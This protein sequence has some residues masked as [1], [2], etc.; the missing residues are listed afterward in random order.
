M[1]TL[2]ESADPGSTF[3]GW[4]GDCTGSGA[5]VVTMDAVKNVTATF[6]ITQHTLTVSLAGTGS[7]TVTSAPAGIDCD[8]DCTEDYDEDTVV[9][10]SPSADPGSTFVAWSG[11]CTGSG[12]CMVTMDAAKNVTA[13]FD[14]SGT[15]QHTL[16]VS[17]AGTGSGTVMSD[18]AGISCD[19]DC[20]EDY[21]EDTVVT[22]TATEDPGST[23]SGWNGAGCSG[24]GDC[25]VTM[26]A[27]KN[28]TAT[29]DTTPSGGEIISLTQVDHFEMGWSGGTSSGTPLTIP[30]TDAAG[31]TY[32]PPSGHLFISDS[33]INEI[34]S[35]FAVAGGNIFEISLSGDTLFNT[36]DTTPTAMGKN[37]EPTG[38]AYCPQSVVDGHAHGHFHISHDNTPTGVWLYELSGGDL[39]WEDQV[40]SPK[41]RDAD[42]SDH[43]DPEDVSCD[44]NTGLKYVIN[45]VEL[46]ILVYSWSA[47]YTEPNPGP[48][49]RVPTTHYKL[50][51]TIDLFAMNAGN[52]GGIPS[53]SEGI[54]YDSVSDQILVVSDPDE[55]IFVYDPTGVFIRKFDIS[56][57]VPAPIAPQGVTLA[58][59]SDGLGGESLYLTDG[60]LDNGSN[61]EERDSAVYEMSVTRSP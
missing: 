9:T 24:T 17:L 57:L 31:I 21:D 1:V 8:P 45:G 22:L 61:P 56:G 34:S 14:I 12:A 32:H 41:G 4:S 3:I 15:P 19:P 13:T 28:V 39:N 58:P 52:P 43:D 38:I 47:S 49:S 26:D 25:V 2:S 60:G 5:C 18:V 40:T 53:D 37:K 29:F 27:P 54:H 55:T 33:E 30:S 51:D 46:N 11:D 6:D 48:S 16:T 23:F 35:A 59:S 7:G 36:F 44:T 20:T 10:L 42:T 50:E